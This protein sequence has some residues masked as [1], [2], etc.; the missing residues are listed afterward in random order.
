METTIPLLN[1]PESPTS[2]SRSYINEVLW[3]VDRDGY[4]VVFL[5]QE[6]LYRVALDDELHLRLIAVSLRHSELAT[7]K[8]I[9]KAFG[10]SEETQRRWERRYEKEGVDGLT[11]RPR[12]G[13][14]RKI[15]KGQEVFVRRWFD[16]GHTNAQIAR[17]LG[18]GEAT[19][20]RALHRL[21]LERPRKP[22]P[23]L[24]FDETQFVQVGDIPDEIDSRVTE[25]KA[26]YGDGVHG[27]V[28]RTC[29]LDRSSFDDDRDGEGSSAGDSMASSSIEVSGQP[30]GPTIDHDPLNRS[31][32]RALA[33]LG[34]LEDAVPL[35]ADA[36]EL[37]RAGVL[38]AI[39]LLVRLGVPQ[40]FEKVY[41][42]LGP[43]F[44]GLRTTLVALFLFALLRIKRPEQLKEYRPC[45]LGR[46]LGLDRA[47]E[48]KTVRR[49][50]NVLARKQRARTLMQ[51]LAQQRIAQDE[52]RI[53]F[54]YIDGHVREYHGK[55]AIA[56]GKKAQRQVAAPSV[57]D[58]WVN[59]SK[60]DPLL[61]VS[62]EMNAG[63]T[64]VLE[65]ILEDVKGLVP[66]D[67]RLTVIFDR[68]GYSPKL[69]VR[70]I[71]AGFDV[72]TYRKGKFR[73]LRRRCFKRERRQING[74]WYT[75]ELCDRGRVKVGRLRTKRKRRT[76]DGGPQFL[77]L[78]QVT[79]LRADG[80]QTHILTSRTDLN[81]VEV[82]YWMFN[83]WRQENFFKYMKEEFALDALVEYGAEEVSEGADRPNPKRVKVHKR[84]EKEKATVQRLQAELGAEAASNQEDT[85]RTMRG[86]KI[87]HRDVRQ[88]LE[89]AESRVQHLSEQ[90][91]KIPKRIPAT[92]LKTLKREKKSIVDS[93]KMSAYQIETDLLRMLQ[94]HYPRSADEG[95]T[96]LHAAFQ[97][98][99]RLQVC[100]EEL[101][102]TIAAQSSPHRT[103]ALAGLCQELDQLNTLFPGTDLRL[104]LAVEPHKPVIS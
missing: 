6:P 61:V 102:V 17:R 47:P 45:D 63:L 96:L 71:E 8:Q 64:Q 32:D 39:P 36:D 58:T 34:L 79:V 29:Q 22:T 73:K 89:Q 68:G 82:S 27:S 28:E 46:I 59:D 1:V 86:F 78:R 55:H 2:D 18:V 19:V 98:P 16:A 72:I 21:G 88:Q 76:G 65:P 51:E 87:A 101:R 33:R 44:Y 91:S 60:G 38:L 43:A 3:F 53:A 92:D 13:G 84:L 77:W 75:Y 9:A 4:R 69:F 97:S 94:T 40:I 80:R 11:P 103:R 99:A 66:S 62:S 48:V 41:K 12:P 5:R 104:R 57:T 67:R 7:Q 54:L 42:S 31:G 24:P 26:K 100:E 83:R 81:A 14:P 49:K 50:L 93:I 20:S 35:F 85:R 25:S 10:H 52:Q 74:K 95:R 37:P 15:D 56:K 30:P 70:L 90:L 23:P